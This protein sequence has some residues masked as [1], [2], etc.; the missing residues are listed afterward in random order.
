MSKVGEE[1]VSGDV[2]MLPHSSV[3]CFNSNVRSSFS[4]SS[5]FS[6]RNMPQFVPQTRLCFCSFLQSQPPLPG[7]A[8]SGNAGLSFEAKQQLQDIQELLDIPD[9]ASLCSSASF[10]DKSLVLGDGS[11]AV[12][13]G[14]TNLD[15]TFCTLDEFVHQDDPLGTWVEIL[16]SGQCVSSRLSYPDVLFY[17]LR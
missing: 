11:P 8:L 13:V 12:P 5:G 16:D 9:G 15:S 3:L 7:P 17:F 10:S 1:D 14:G 2:R 4:A 6:V